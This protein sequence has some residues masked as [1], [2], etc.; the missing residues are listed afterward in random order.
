MNKG[1]KFSAGYFLLT[2]L[3]V[4]LFGDLVYKP[5]IASQTEVPYSTFLSDLERGAI[6]DVSLADDRVVYSLKPAKVSTRFGPVSSV[7]R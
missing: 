4:W 5:Y 2:L 7:N 6:A 1:Q 3:V